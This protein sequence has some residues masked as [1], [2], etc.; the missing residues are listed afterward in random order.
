MELDKLWNW[1]RKKLACR[2]RQENGNPAGDG[3]REMFAEL[4]GVDLN[5]LLSEMKTT[6]KKKEIT[7]K[8][9][10]DHEG[11]KNFK[12][13]LSRSRVLGATKLAL[14]TMEEIDNQKANSVTNK[15]VRKVYQLLPKSPPKRVVL[16]IQRERSKPLRLPDQTEHK[17]QNDKIEKKLLK[18]RAA[19]MA[20]AIE[21]TAKEEAAKQKN[22]LDVNAIAQLMQNCLPKYE[23]DQFST[24]DRLKPILPI[25]PHFLFPSYLISRW[26][27]P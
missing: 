2:I 24:G 9:L 14:D 13:V 1:Q 25:V 7:N 23:G 26:S 21:V 4:A 15:N 17:A 10:V 5:E 12:E 3:L 22:P 19:R 20:A 11:D 27:V 8:V 6:K 16:E 18:Q